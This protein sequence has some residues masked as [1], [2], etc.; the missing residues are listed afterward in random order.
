MASKLS[1]V[2]PML[3]SSWDRLKLNIQGLK[4]I[5]V[6]ALSPFLLNPFTNEEF[7]FKLIK[8][9]ILISNNFKGWR[10]TLIFEHLLKNDLSPLFYLNREYLKLYEELI[11]KLKSSIL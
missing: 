10:V 9:R 1:D 5:I 6:T 2:L 4:H 11:K 3:P 7:Y 8:L